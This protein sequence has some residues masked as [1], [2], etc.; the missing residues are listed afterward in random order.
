M[1]I[2][3]RCIIGF[4]DSRAHGNPQLLEVHRPKM[5]AADCT[6]A[7]ARYVRILPKLTGGGRNF[8]K[9]KIEQMQEG[10]VRFPNTG[11]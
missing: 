8:D 10:L 4:L 7:F 1:G 2:L 11:N 9:F 6:L 3:Y 5:Q